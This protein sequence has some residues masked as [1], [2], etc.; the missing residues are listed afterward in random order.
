VIGFYFGAVPSR[1]Y[2]K[3][4]SALTSIVSNNTKLNICLLSTVPYNSTITYLEN[5][6]FKNSKCLKLGDSC[7]CDKE[8]LCFASRS[9]DLSQSL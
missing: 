8:V 7:T 4:I 2:E 9:R 1:D 3:F 5:S 6:D